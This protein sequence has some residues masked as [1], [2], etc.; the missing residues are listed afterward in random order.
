[1]G[2]GLGWINGALDQ[3]ERLAVNRFGGGDEREC[4]CSGDGIQVIDVATKDATVGLDELEHVAGEWFGFGVGAGT[5]ED[6]GDE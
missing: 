2:M 1:M 6:G 3:D 5:S 4:D